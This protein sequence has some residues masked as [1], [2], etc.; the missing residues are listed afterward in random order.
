MAYHHGS[1]L[2][3]GDLEQL[4]RLCLLDPSFPAFVEDVEKKLREISEE[5][6]YNLSVP[7][8]F[9]GND[10]DP[11]QCAYCSTLECLL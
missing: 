6:G 2:P 4:L 11:L 10:T 9:D 5:W 7:F 8:L 3:P 1:T